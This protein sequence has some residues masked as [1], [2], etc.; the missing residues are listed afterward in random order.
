[1]GR[2][3]ASGGGRPGG[4]PGGGPGAGRMGGGPHAGGPGSMRTGHGPGPQPPRHGA[5][6][7]PHR[8]FE[9]R[10]RPPFGIILRELYDIALYR[11]ALE[12][13]IRWERGYYPRP[14]EF[15]ILDRVFGRRIAAHEVHELY[16]WL[17]DEIRYL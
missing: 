12:I 5:P 13:L 8:R 6:P 14:D 7:P 10:H 1:M 17:D 11:S 9:P 4:R 3:G 15:M 2:A 16:R